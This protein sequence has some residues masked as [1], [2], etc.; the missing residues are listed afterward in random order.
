[1]YQEYLLRLEQVRRVWAYHLNAFLFPLHRANNFFNSLVQFIQRLTKF[2]SVLLLESE[3][4]LT[5]DFGNVFFQN[6]KNEKD[7]QA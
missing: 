1:M 5:N 2:T 3:Y 6:S 7:L 4:C